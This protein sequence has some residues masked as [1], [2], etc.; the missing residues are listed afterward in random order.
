MRAPSR[1]RA[2]G[3]V[4][5]GVTGADANDLPAASETSTTGSHA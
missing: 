1:P 2:T 4:I 3:S 5:T